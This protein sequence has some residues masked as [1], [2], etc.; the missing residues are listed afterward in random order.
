MAA[1]QPRNH[2]EHRLL[3]EMMC[4]LRAPAR[5]WP[6]QFP[7]VQFPLAVH[8]EHGIC[9]HGLAGGQQAPAR[10]H[11]T[12]VALSE[13]LAHDIQ[14]GCAL[15]GIRFRRNDGREVNFRVSHA[16]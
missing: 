5:R 3:G 10:D 16:R 7:D 15:H 2:G 12:S 11:L 1:T 9:V 4:E 6:G 8:H 14:H 13:I